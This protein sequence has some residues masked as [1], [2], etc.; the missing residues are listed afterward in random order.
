MIRADLSAAMRFRRALVCLAMTLVALASGLAAREPAVAAA[1][2]SP[3]HHNLAQVSAHLRIAIEIRPAQLAEYL[4][5]SELVCGLGE[6]SEGRGDEPGAAANWT[7]LSQ[8]VRELDRRET[9]AIDDAFARADS[10]LVALRERFLRAWRGQPDRVRELKR[11]VA[12][13][14]EG[15]RL[16]RQAMDTVAAAFSKWEG[17]D[18]G[19]AIDGIEAGIRQIPAGLDK[20]N[21]GMQRLW[22]LPSG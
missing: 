22:R 13:T 10:D 16:L 1:A 15:I 11:G 7:T 3:Y 6:K 18:C 5:S 14:R 2:P 12:R 4:R 19:A 20:V 9:R 21:L 17:R 8:L